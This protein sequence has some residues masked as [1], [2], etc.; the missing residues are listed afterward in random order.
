[1]IRSRTW[2]CLRASILVTILAVAGV[3]RA[4][5]DGDAP[6]ATPAEQVKIAKDFKI[7]LLYNVPKDKQGSWVSMCVD[8]KGRLIVSDQYGGLFRITPGKGAADTNIEALD[9]KLGHA[10]GLLYAFDS[11]Y[12]MVADDKPFDRGLWRVRADGDKF[13]APELL[14][15]LEGG[16]EH[17]PHAILLSPDKHSIYCVIGNQTKMTDL[18]GSKVPQVWSEDHLLPRMPDG[19]GFMA[20][21]LGPGGCIYKVD[22]DGKNW[23]LQTTGFRN[24]Y[25]AAFMKN[26]DL[27]AYDADMEWDMNTPWYRPTRVCFAMTG[28]DYGWRN[29]TGKWPVHY[30]DTVPPVID[31]GFGSP[32]GVT[33]GYGAKFPAKYQDALFICDWSYGKLYAIH[34]SP[35]GASYKADKELFASAA[36]L[37]LTDIV[38]NPTDGAMYFTVGGR[39][40]QSGLYR[41]T[42]TGPEPTTPLTDKPILTDAA[43]TRRALAAF[44]GKVDPA[45]LDLAWPHLGSPDRFV[46]AAARAAVES[47]PVEKWQARALAEQ[48]PQ[49]AITALIALVRCSQ[50][51]EFHRKPTDSPA[52][53]ALQG[54]V[55]AALERIDFS[56]LP[57]PQRLELLRAY[58]LTFIRLGKPDD[59]VAKAVA[60]RFDPYF[61]A[62]TREMNA[63]LAELLI[64]VQSEKV[65]AK[66]VALLSSAPTQE[67]QLEMAK[68]L[69]M[70]KVGWTLD[71]RK[72]Y[73]EWFQRAAGYRGGNSFGLFVEHIRQEA[74]ASLPPEDKSALKETL[75]AKPKVTSPQE[76]FA[77]VLKGRQVVKEWKVDDLS[78]DLATG[79]KGRNFDNGRKFA[80]AVGCFA[81]HRFGNEGGAVGPDLTGVAGR[82]SPRD[83]LESIITPSKEVSD[84]YQQVI[85][86]Q[87]KGDPVIG[88]IV[89]LHDDNYSVMVNMYDPN[90]LKSVKA[91]NVKEVRVSK[92]SPMPEGLLNLLQKD[93]ILDLMAY[94]LSGGDKTNKAFA[95]N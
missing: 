88:R 19:R 44:H 5:A 49:S 30:A 36:P 39:K 21:V 51:D 27:F 60:S 55:L 29:G 40:T 7:E 9:V 16:G 72:Q 8:P 79:M 12:V 70:L 89:N 61:P 81:C 42:Y 41:V 45:A 10:Q 59:A 94:L 56:K 80:G 63:M 93:E 65:G 68:S 38:I 77:S 31:I 33:F 92:L 76:A 83:L 86:V 6:S 11:L 26:G 53:P 69:R 67:E 28:V 66:A 52:D 46:R 58:G 54:K 50:K 34:I 95:G 57:D 48:D 75:E 13:G 17:G 37:P 35:D 64:Y 47:Q 85:L 20:G 25:D 43:Q 74:I 73:F 4:Q 2:S 3:A 87:K 24:E 23:E 15:K 78:A 14:R 62:A 32:T 1:M 18:A 90:D 71:L 22:P 91:S 82:F 84:Q